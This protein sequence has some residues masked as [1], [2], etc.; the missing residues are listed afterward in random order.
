MSSV[1]LVSQDM[2]LAKVVKEALRESGARLTSIC[3]DSRS[4]AESF[5]QH[6][7]ILVVLETF[8]PDSSGLEMLKML[9]RMNEKCLFV[10]LSRMRTRSM[11]ERAFRLG[12][13]DVLTFPLDEE[14]LRQTILHRLEVQPL[15]MGADEKEG[16][17]KKQEARRK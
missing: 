17:G 12:A 4:A 8:L 2:Q 10:M 14:S 5:Q 9:K 15:D 13:H 7:P 1:M 16:E 3:G 11:I 6:P